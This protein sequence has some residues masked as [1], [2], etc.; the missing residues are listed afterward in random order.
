M[1]T[2]N[3]ISST[4]V[5]I[6]TPFDNSTNGYVATNVQAAIE[7]TNIHLLAIEVSAT[8]NATTTSGTDALLTT[9]TVN[10]AGGTY[11][12]FF[13]ASANSNNAGSVITFSVYNNNV[14]DA[15]T[16]RLVSPFDGGAL[17]VASATGVVSIQRTVVV[18]AGTSIQIRW[19][20]SGGTATCSARTLTMLRIA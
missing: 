8:A 5:A 2:G 15:S 18:T 12:L 7:E 3:L 1:S 9:M 17:S 11:I 4:Q 16:I 10:P 20:T 19:N 13:S 14:Q 6:S